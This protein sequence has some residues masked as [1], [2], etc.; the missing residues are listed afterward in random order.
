MQRHYQVILEGVLAVLILIELLSMSLMTVGFIAGLKA[1]TIYSFGSLD[2]MIALFILLDLIFFRIRKRDANKTK[3]QFLHANW[4]YIVSAIPLT[5]ISF[6]LFQL[7]G[8]KPIIGLIG[9]VRIYALIRV[10]VISARSV[11]KYPSKTK[12]DYATFA[13]FLVII[14][15]SYL[16][17]AIETSVNPEVPNYES[18]IWYALVSMSTTGYGDVVPITL[19]GRIIGVILI[20]TGMGYVSLVT[21][22]LAYSFID[23]FRTESRK[24]AEKLRTTAQDL[25]KKAAKNEKKMDEIMEKMDEI[26]QKLD[27]MEKREDK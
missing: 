7:F 6:N 8:W 9:I 19:A 17:F 22:T 14:L 23:I 4:V 13:L 5:F 3:W 15:G 11:R 16:F 12:L 21:A 24:A 10:L 26:N 20:L 25:D 2:V 18:A 27:E 1:E